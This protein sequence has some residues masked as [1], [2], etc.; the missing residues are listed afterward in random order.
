MLVEL[1]EIDNQEIEENIENTH[2][3]AIYEM[4]QFDYISEEDLDITKVFKSN[5]YND[6]LELINFDEIRLNIK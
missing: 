3:D 2:E 5:Y 1:S 4:E 6:H